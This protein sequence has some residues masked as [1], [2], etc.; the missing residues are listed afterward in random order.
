MTTKILATLT[1]IVGGIAVVYSVL[2]AF[3]IEV[4]QDQ[5]DAVSGLLGLIL[6][7]AGIWL[8]PSVPVGVQTPPDA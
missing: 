5:Q 3:G 1:A 2:G 7:V 8:H 6:I 4:S